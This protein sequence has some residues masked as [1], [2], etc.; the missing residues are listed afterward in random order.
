MGDGVYAATYTPPVTRTSTVV[1]VQASLGSNL[2]QS[3]A[4]DVKILPSRP[5][6]V[7]ITDAP[8]G[9][10]GIAASHRFAS[11]RGAEGQTLE[12]LSLWSGG[13][14]NALPSVS[15]HVGGGDYRVDVAS[16]GGQDGLGWVF[17]APEPSA[18]PVAGVVL[19]PVLDSVRPGS[20]QVVLATATDRFGYPGS[21]RSDHG[22]DSVWRCQPRR[23][24]GRVR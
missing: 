19:V 1:T 23:R 8:P 6:S 18:N 9:E 4:I 15:S 2:V 20:P 7:V 3:D 11:V 16:T 5:A 17:A 10:A 14:T 21:E 24:S 13:F 22:E 12:T